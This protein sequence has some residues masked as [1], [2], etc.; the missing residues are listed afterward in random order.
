MRTIYVDKNIPRVLLT[1]AISPLW[2]DFV[3]TPLS[4]ARAA[5]L[6]DPPLPGPRWLRLRNERC[7]ICA[8]DLSLLFVHA[9]PS[10]APAALP[11]LSRFWLGHETASVVTEVGPGVRRF[12]VG[13]RVIMDTH[14]SFSANCATMEI[15]PKCR[16]CAEGDYQFCINKSEPGARGIGGGFGDG[17]VTHEMAVYPAAPV[18]NAEQAAMTE[19]L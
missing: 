18:L 8:S 7:G 2:L 12:R 16:Y 14:F 13:D 4:S 5:R 3:W 9:D 15:E 19:P 17:C 11:G 1:K 6:A 10:A